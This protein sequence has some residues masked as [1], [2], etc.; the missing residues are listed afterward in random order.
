MKL[1]AAGL[2]FDWMPKFRTV[3]AVLDLSYAFLMMAQ[4]KQS[5]Q[6]PS[7]RFNQS[8]A[9]I[10]IHV[11]LGFFIINIGVFLQVENEI[12][13]ITKIEDEGFIR[14]VLYYVLG[15]ATV[16][17]SFT[18]FAIL[19]KVMGEKRITVPLYFVA[20]SINL[21]NSIALLMEPTLQ[22]AFLVWGSVNTFVYVRAFLLVL[23]FAHLD[24]ELMYTYSVL[25][26]AAITYPLTG[27]DIRVFYG[28]AAP[29]VY[30]PFH[31]RVCKWFPSLAFT[32]EDLAGGNTPSKKNVSAF[33]IAARTRVIDGT[34]AEQM[35]SLVEQPPVTADG[36]VILN[37][38]DETSGITED[39]LKGNVFEDDSSSALTLER[40]LEAPPYFRRSRY[41][42]SVSVAEE[43][44][45][46]SQGEFSV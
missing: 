22:N 11:L 13:H 4:R 39:Q 3:T 8:R 23:A 29:I 10:L 6:F 2:E 21:G 27:Q 15:V 40:F 37:D 41:N 28:L 16:V 20:G 38:Q 26:A 18:I 7:A 31:E 14:Q 46:E 12:Y 34:Y 44:E 17:H 35:A 32:P 9:P 45:R 36:K 25:A 19:S 43:E 33:T 42:V 24:W 1:Y 5:G 30:A